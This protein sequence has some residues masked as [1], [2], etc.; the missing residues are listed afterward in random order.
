MILS[1]Q[2][3]VLY[4]AVGQKAALPIYHAASLEITQLATIT[5]AAHPGF[6]VRHR[7]ILPAQTMSGL[8]DDFLQLD[9]RPELS[10]LHIGY[11]G[12]ADQV[13]QVAGFC[14]KARQAH[15]QIKILI[16]P[17]FGDGN[18]RYVAD[19]IIQAVIDKLVPMADIITPNHFELSLLSGAIIKDQ[20][21]A[22]D[23]LTT[24]S[25]THHLI[26]C[27]TGL[28]LDEEPLIYDVIMDKQSMHRCSQEARPQGVSGAGDSFAALLLSALLKGKDVPEALSFASNITA[29]M[30]AQS[31]SPL[32]LN[33]ASGL[34]MI[35]AKLDEA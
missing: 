32:T 20:N 27:V 30:I 29:H 10:A 1:I 13:N 31:K 21:T 12:S 14:E 19:D 26:A 4:G 9:E 5:L 3:D 2:S 17:V 22:K 15:P 23:A 28:K 35:S 16:D 18:R 8:L 11:F 33:V 25:Q 6:G 7:S 34:S 24:L